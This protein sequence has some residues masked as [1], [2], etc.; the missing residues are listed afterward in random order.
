MKYR[1]QPGWPGT[2]ILL[3]CL[4]VFIKLGLWQQ[5]KAEAKQSLQATLD[6]RSLER[7]V[8]MPESLPNLE[9]W[10]Y[11][12]VVLR[13]RYDD[14]YQILLDNQVENSEAGYHVLTPLR[15]ENSETV[16]LVNRGW[17]AAGTDRARLP[18]ATVPPDPQEIH[19]RVW[20]PPA[21]FFALQPEPSAGSGWQKVW[22]NIDLPRYGSMVPFKVLPVVVRLDA[23]S[24]GGYLRNWPRPAER[25]EKHLSYAYQWYGFAITAILIYLVINV[26]RK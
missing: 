8:A 23:D 20:L 9:E 13:G 17:V 25:M 18:E 1:F 26:R 2:L 15:L 4:T 19:G 3:V 10:R 14:R 7:P 5:H 12:R 6:E 22:Q 16:V 24:T 11:R 21:K